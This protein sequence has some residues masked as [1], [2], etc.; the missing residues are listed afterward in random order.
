MAAYSAAYHGNQVMLLEKNSKLGVKILMSGGTRCNIT[1]DCD[2]QGIVKAFGRNGRF[3]YSALAAMP[4][5]AVV[6]LFNANGVATKVESTGKVFPISNR[7]I[8][9]R[10]ALVSLAT[11]AGADIRTHTPVTNLLNV[12]NDVDQEGKFLI[13]TADETFAAESVIL[14]TGGKSWAGCGTTGDGY[15]WAESFG[16]EIVRTVPSLTPLVCQTSWANDLKGITIDPVAV[17]VWDRSVE[18]GDNTKRKRSKKPVATTV[19][20]FLFTHFGFSGPAAMDVSREFATSDSPRELRLRCDFRN[21]ETADQIALWLKSQKQ[22]R[23]G[24]QVIRVLAELFPRRLAEALLTSAVVPFDQKVAELSMASIENIVSA[25]KA[26][27]FP[28]AGTLGF[29]KAEVTAGGVNL[30]QV[31]GQTME[32]KLTPG[33]FFAGEILDLDGP[34]GGYN[35]QAAWSTGWVAGMCVGG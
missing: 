33:L 18:T 26:T 19:G 12:A 8:D 13:E 7:A 2:V 30:K 27:E 11:D 29:D 3:L 34:I 10:D 15:P 14:T 32:S 21:H 4:P 24:Q 25:V 6:D 1:H 35:F 23:G 16:H 20:S 5:A 31:N 9:V 17:S 22:E 28:I